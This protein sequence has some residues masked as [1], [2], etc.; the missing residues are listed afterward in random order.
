METSNIEIHKRKG[1]FHLTSQIPEHDNLIVREVIS[2]SSNQDDLSCTFEVIYAY[3]KKSQAQIIHISKEQLG[4]GVY[5]LKPNPPTINH[6]PNDYGIWFEYQPHRF[7]YKMMYDIMLNDGSIIQSCYPNGITFSCFN[8]KQELSVMAKS[9]LERNHGE[10]KDSCV[11]AIRLRPIP[12]KDEED[13]ELMS[14]SSYNL[15]SNFDI[16]QNWIVGIK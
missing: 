11:K 12:T 13:E 6:L 5:T 3:N 2:E 4:N 15:I 16:F 10:I 7:R 14:N 9:F 8:H 1:Y